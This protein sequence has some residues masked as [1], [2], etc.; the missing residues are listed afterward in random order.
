[1]YVIY[2]ESIQLDSTAESKVFRAESST[3]VST[4]QLFNDKGNHLIQALT[5][6]NSMLKTILSMHGM[7]VTVVYI[8]SLDWTS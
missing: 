6:T 5:S 8:Q 7:L 2:L 4:E 3:S 1:M